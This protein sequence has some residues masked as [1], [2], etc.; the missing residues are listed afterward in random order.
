MSDNKFLSKLSQNLLEILNDE[1]YYDITIEVAILRYIYGGS[2]SIG[3]YDTSDIIKILIAANELNLQ[4]L[5]ISDTVI[6]YRDILPKELY[7]DLLSTLLNLHPDSMSIIKSKPRKSINVDS[8]IITFKHAELILKWIDK[9]SITDKLTSSYE[10]KL[11]L[12]G[13]RDGFAPSKF[14]EICDGQS[15]TVSVIKVNDSNE[16]LGGYNPI[17]WKSECSYSVTKDSFIFSFESVDSIEKHILSRVKDEQSAIFNAR[18]CGPL[19]GKQ[20]DDLTIRDRDKS[21][22][23]KCSYKK[24]IRKIEDR[25]F[26]EEY[27]VF[28]IIKKS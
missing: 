23:K 5:E 28:Q 20:G 21:Y 6:P 24:R 25:F 13:T 16:I 1:E 18:N 11:I 14:H 12:R 7:V 2:L 8:N 9:L 22:S 26:A 15:R 19:F 3:K 10:F 27:E 17:E 4:E